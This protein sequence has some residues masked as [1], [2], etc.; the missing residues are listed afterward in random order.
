MSSKLVRDNIP[1]IA[2]AQGKK[3]K[4]RTASK[5]EMLSL[6]TQKLREETSEFLEAKNAEEL[7]DI[8]EVVLNLSAELGVDESSLLEIMKKKRERN[9]GFSRRIVMEFAP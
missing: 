7:A 2:A 6:L 5:E 4:F 8:L 9:G 3:F 1:E